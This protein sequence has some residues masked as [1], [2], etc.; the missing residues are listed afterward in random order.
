MVC[1]RRLSLASTLIL[2][3]APLA[4]TSD[5]AMNSGTSGVTGA[6]ATQGTTTTTG[7]GS[8]TS[9]ASGTGT[10]GGASDSATTGTGSSAGS[11]GTTVNPIFDVGAETD[12]ETGGGEVI[13]C[14]DAA[15]KPSNIGCEFWAVDMDQQDAFNDPASAPWGVAISPVAGGQTT[16]TI[17]INLA[18]PGEPLDLMIIEELNIGPDEVVPVEL[19]TRELDCGAMPNDYNAPGTCL[20]SNAFR[21]TSSSPVVVYQFNV[22]KNAFSNDASLLLPTPALGKNYRVLGWP[23]GHPIKVLG[24]I[25]DRSA[26]TIVGTEP[27]TEVKIAPS[28]RIKGNGP[29]P[30]IPAGGSYITKIGPFDVLNLETADGTFQDDVKKIADL[31]GTVVTSDKPIAVFS[32]VESTAAPGGVVDIPT[33]PDWNSD[34]TCCLDHLEEQLFP[35]ESIGKNYVITRSPIRSTG[36]YHEPDVIRFVGVAEDAQ[37]TTSLPPPFDSFT[38]KPG[39]VRTTWADADFVAT[40]TKPF[41]IAQLLISQEYVDGP[42]T[43]DP[44]LT[45]FPPVDQ[46]RDEYRILTPSDD[47]IWGWAKNF[48]VLSTPPTN[49]VTIDGVEPQGCVITPAGM[50]NGTEYESR[51]CPV[52]AGVHSLKGTAGFGVIA[53]GYGPAGSYAFPGGADAEQIYVPPQ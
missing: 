30:P 38:L 21:I 16:V 48:V 53:Y 5:D 20:S 27:D 44:A 36:S 1:A 2:L 35:V 42:Y 22:F 6:S 17:E 10:T 18:A 29:I 7:A 51:R 50:V 8:S 23:A 19:P 24:G 40:A 31:T 9:T 4:C 11:S 28:W 37:V 3:G 33:Y 12:G 39:D 49:V 43:G 15:N 34:D 25:I 52:S 32:G 45:V 26:V 13:T 47:G 14:L 46:Y 41:M